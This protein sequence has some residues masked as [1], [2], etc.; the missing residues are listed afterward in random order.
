[1]FRKSANIFVF[2]MFILRFRPNNTDIIRLF[3]SQYVTDYSVSV[4]ARSRYKHL[5]SIIL[6]KSA[7]DLDDIFVGSVQEC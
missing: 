1:M 3:S 2:L 4:N 5:S 6:K 7:K